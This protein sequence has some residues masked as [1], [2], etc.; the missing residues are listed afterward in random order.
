MA[1]ISLNSSALT[2][3]GNARV[4]N[5]G[6]NNLL[7]KKKDFPLNVRSTFNPI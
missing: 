4:A 6:F 5:K 3:V 2:A 1:F 7:I